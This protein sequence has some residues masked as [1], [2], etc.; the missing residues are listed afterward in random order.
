MLTRPQIQDDWAPLPVMDD[1]RRWVVDRLHHLVATDAIDLDEFEVLVAAVWRADSFGELQAVQ[2][3]AP[4]PPPPSPSRERVIG[5]FGGERRAGG[6]RPMPITAAVATFG[7]VRLDLTEAEWDGRM[8]CI[9]A[10]AVCGGVEVVV[11]GGVDVTCEGSVVVDG[12]RSGG[13]VDAAS[14]T[15]PRVRVKAQ[16]V[17]G[18]VSVRRHPFRSWVAPG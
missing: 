3:R 16:S 1:D 10:L 2:A 14:P 15:T 4:L 7:N 18:H 13:R 11:P 5:A 9:D 12:P 8:L 6:W 17:L